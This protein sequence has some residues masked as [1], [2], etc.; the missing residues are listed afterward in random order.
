LLAQILQIERIEII[1]RLVVE[2]G[3]MS[4]TLIDY[5]VCLA[6][7]RGIHI[8]DRTRQ[9]LAAHQRIALRLQEPLGQQLF[10]KD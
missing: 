6:H 10:G 5:K 9:N 8:A 4:I 7:H 3:G 2:D 1:G